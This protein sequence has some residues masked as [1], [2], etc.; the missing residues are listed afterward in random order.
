MIEIVML[1]EVADMRIKPPSIKPD[2]RVCKKCE[3][4]PLFLI[5]YFVFENR[6]KFHKIIN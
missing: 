1:N 2:I 4:I 6:V 5:T 3:M